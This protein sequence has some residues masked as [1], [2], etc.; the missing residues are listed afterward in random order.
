MLSVELGQSMDPNSAHRP[1]HL[2]KCNQIK[3]KVIMELIQESFIEFSHMGERRNK[4]KQ[5]HSK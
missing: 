5:W 4:V 1:A 2:S 3:R